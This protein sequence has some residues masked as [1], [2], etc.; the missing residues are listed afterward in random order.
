MT[1]RRKF[2]YCYGLL[3]VLL[4]AIDYIMQCDKMCSQCGLT[5]T[6]FLK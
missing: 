1:F 4:S 5:N 6:V 3:L 2:V